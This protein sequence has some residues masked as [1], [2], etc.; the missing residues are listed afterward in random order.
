[1]KRSKKIADQFNVEMLIEDIE[2]VE[3]W[4]D[5]DVDDEQESWILDI[6]NG[7][8]GI[9]QTMEICQAFDLR[10][11]KDAIIPGYLGDTLDDQYWSDVVEPTFWDA[12]DILNRRMHKA[13]LDNMY[14]VGFEFSEAD[15]CY[16]LMAYRHNK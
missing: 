2:G 12:A 5:V 4:Y 7:A 14:A 1:M 6:G 3:H 16:C 13:G 8:S 10:I 11:P 9:Y 15:S